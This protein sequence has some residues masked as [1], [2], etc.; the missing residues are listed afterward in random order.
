MDWK[1]K[2]SSRKLWLS[3]E[4][5]VSMLIIAIGGT[6]STATQISALIMAGASVIRYCMAEGLADTGNKSE[7][8][9]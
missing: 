9:Q 7:I 5:S 6:E 4:S 2:L 1:R 8:L 3:I